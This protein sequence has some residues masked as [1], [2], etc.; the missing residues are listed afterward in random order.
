[1]KA[2][3]IAAG[4]IAAVLAAAPA[5]A[6]PLNL[7]SVTG[8]GTLG[9]TNLDRDGGGSPDFSAITGRLGAR[10]GPYLGVEGELSG[11]LNSDHVSTAAGPAD[12]RMHLQYAGYGVGFL[13]LAP[14]ADLFARIGYGQTQFHGSA[15]GTP[16]HGDDDS[17]NL[18]AGGQYFFDRS[19]GL[20][21][22]YTRFNYD[23]GP[24]A[25][26]WSVA[27]VRKF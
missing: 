13:P 15:S 3:L 9:Y 18:G 6:D 16:F 19:N 5:F 2:T 7:N 26:V 10:F 14:N 23:H 21:A 22:D 24:D 11:G 17:W 8:Y 25:N 20:R 12:V 1:M 27:F 4:A